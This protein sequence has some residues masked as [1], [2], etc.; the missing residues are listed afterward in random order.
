[1]SIE[2]FAIHAVTLPG[3]GEIGICRMPGRDGRLGWNVGTIARWRP[4]I[5][6]SLTPAGEGGLNVVE[7]LPELLAPHGI[8]H[9]NFPIVDYGAPED[10]DTAWATLAAKLHPVLDAGRRLLVHCMGGCGRS[11]MV[12]LRLM[13]ERGELPEAAFQRLRAV[14]PCAVETEGQREWAA[15]PPFRT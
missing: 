13:V 6:V 5:L 2:R 10:G 4:E 14:R 15:P 8:R 9:C 7:R 11:G 3:G 1:V 12:A